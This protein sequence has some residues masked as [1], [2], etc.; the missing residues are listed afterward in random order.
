MMIHDTALLR[1]LVSFPVDS[2]YTRPYSLVKKKHK[3]NPARLCSCTA[4]AA[5]SHNTGA[6]IVLGGTLAIE[7]RN[8]R[9]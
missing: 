7:S 4:T 5:F 1:A 9:A 3:K 8:Q 6:M 2:V